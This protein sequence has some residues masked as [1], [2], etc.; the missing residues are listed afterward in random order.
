MLKK[1]RKP[2]RKRT[3]LDYRR[4]WMF[5]LII[6]ITSVLSF[7]Y[8]KIFGTIVL[9]MYNPYYFISYNSDTFDVLMIILLGIVIISSAAYLFRGFNI[10]RKKYLIRLSA[11]AIIMLIGITILN[12]NMWTFDKD[13][14]SYNTIF[15]KNKIVYS[16]DNIDSAEVEVYCGGRKQASPR[17]NYALHMHNGKIVKFNAYYACYTDEDKIIEFDKSIADKRSVVEDDYDHNLY[18]NEKLN[19]YYSSLYK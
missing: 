10:S 3:S 5:I 13:T 4:S 17:I 2:D 1:K 9:N 7:A 19:E 16:Y 11:I 8:E 12:C 14:F 15:Q 18:D 6:V